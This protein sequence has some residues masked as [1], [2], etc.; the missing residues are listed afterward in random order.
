LKS[1]NDHTQFVSQEGHK[2]QEINNKKNITTPNGQ[3]SL[4]SVFVVEAKRKDK[5]LL[6]STFSK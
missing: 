3:G 2:Y 1:I 5:T 4:N 6:R